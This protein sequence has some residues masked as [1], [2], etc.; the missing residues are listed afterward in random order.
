MLLYC[1]H[2][3]PKSGKYGAAIV[4]LVRLA[5]VATVLALGA[6]LLLLSRRQRARLRAVPGGS[7]G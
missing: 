3:D 4:N 1:F 7:G 5:G 6:S 2:Y